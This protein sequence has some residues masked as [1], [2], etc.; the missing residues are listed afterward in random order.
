MS[1]L[2]DFYF[3]NPQPFIKPL[4]MKVKSVIS[5]L[6]KKEGLPFPGTVNWGLDMDFD[7]FRDDGD[8][9]S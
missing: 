2:S 8:S 7:Y 9:I 3:P 5:Y 4:A 1:I 6:E